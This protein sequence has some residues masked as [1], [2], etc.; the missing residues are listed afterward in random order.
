MIRRSFLEKVFLETKERLCSLLELVA[1]DL[2]V[3]VEG[4]VSGRLDTRARRV[5]T[6]V[7]IE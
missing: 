7:T 2:D 5:T 6:T 3:V 4:D 1:A